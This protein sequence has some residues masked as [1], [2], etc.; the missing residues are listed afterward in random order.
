[1]GEEDGVKLEIAKEMAEN[2][3]RRRG[4]IR[5][6]GRRRCGGFERR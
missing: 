5:E 4:R 1:M 6:E 2:C 3:Q